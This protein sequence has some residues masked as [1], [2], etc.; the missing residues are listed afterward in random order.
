MDLKLDVNRTGFTVTHDAVL[1]K[2]FETGQPKIDKTTGLPQYAV[3]MLALDA[4]GGEVV[5]V[6]VPGDPKVTVGQQV[7]V[8]NLI[9]LPW[10]QNGKS[11][12]AFRAD[13]I[14]AADSKPAAPARS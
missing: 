13:A 3:Q 9:A 6:T 14:T 12:I 2:V 11:G 5:T 8:T 7:T 10:S 1:R 4:T